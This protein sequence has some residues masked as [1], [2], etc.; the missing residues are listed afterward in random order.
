MKCN[1]CKKDMSNEKTGSCVFSKVKIDGKEYE[2]NVK[3]HDVNNRCHDCNIVNG[4][5]HHF[6]CDMERCPKCKEQFVCCDCNNGTL[7]FVK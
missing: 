1:Y 4:K 6:G 2:R 7:Q 5:I 3:Y